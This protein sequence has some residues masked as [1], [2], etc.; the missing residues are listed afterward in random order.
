MSVSFGPGVCG[1]LEEAS[2]R[3]WLVTDGLGG[4]AMGTVGGLRTRRYHGLLIVAMDG[5][6]SRM[7]GLTALDPVIV[8]GDTRVRL[9]TA[10][11]VGGAVDPTG[12][13]LLASFTLASGVPRWRWQIGG[14]V[15]EREVAMA[16]GRSAVGVVHRLVRGEGPAHLELTPL[17]TWRSVHGERSAVATPS[18]EPTVDGFVFEGV[19]RLA[20]PG[21]T[22]AATGT[23]VCAG[24]RKPH[25]A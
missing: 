21:W 8:I 7:M 9:A 10:E 12:H 16:H 20:G 5:P 17:C 15:V 24:A 6:S 3:E 25:V 13:A 22:P 14:T 2:R 11:W 4:Y 1:N 18:V 23:A 19:Y